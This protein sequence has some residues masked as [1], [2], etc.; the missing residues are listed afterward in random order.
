M[1]LQII[2][3]Q[4]GPG[5]IGY[6]W[7]ACEGGQ[8]EEWRQSVAPIPADKVAEIIKA[9]GDDLETLTQ[10]NNVLPPSGELK[11][12]SNSNYSEDY[13]NYDFKDDSV[14]FEKE[15]IE[16]FPGMNR[17]NSLLTIGTFHR[18]IS[19]SG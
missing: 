4:V 9:M 6:I 17:I 1:K 3:Y 8:E 2:I 18:F 14:D 11:F 12:D 15:V 13:D 10:D 7:P 5:G 19:H 16:M